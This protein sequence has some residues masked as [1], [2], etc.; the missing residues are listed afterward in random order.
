MMIA[1]LL[2]NTELHGGNRV[3]MDQGEELVRRGHEVE[4]WS[5]SGPP[6]WHESPVRF[7]Q[8]DIF[9]GEL[10]HPDVCIATFW[11]TV[12]PACATGASRVFHLC[13][14]FEGIHE[15]YRPQL[16]SIDEAYRRPIRKL[17]ISSHLADILRDRYGI[18]AHLIGTGIDLDTFCP[19]PGP[20][21]SNV[22]R[23]GVVGAYELRPKGVKEA[24]EGLRLARDLG[25]SF[26]L[27][28]ASSSG[29]TPE[30]HAL[31]LKARC[32]EHLST[33]KMV[34]F[35]RSVDCLIHGSW[36]EEG[37]GLPPLEAGACGCAVA[38]TDIDPMTAF[39]KTSVL[40]FPP[41]RSD[42]IPEVVRQLQDAETRRLL[43]SSFL[44]DVG[45]FDIHKVVDRLESALDDG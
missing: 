33:K 40:R 2:P 6:D 34:E 11:P 5:P 12:E 20:G 19:A 28:R 16:P 3:P 23:I 36:N 18:Q 24:L 29:F 43:R 45:R 27:W 15:E 26:E 13:Q 14:G 10:P 7:V 31:G 4:I 8:A 38:A 21:D 37:F 32:F 22:L 1:Y 9:A 42:V 17:V 41:G 25:L 35:Y 44:S 30:E 39:S